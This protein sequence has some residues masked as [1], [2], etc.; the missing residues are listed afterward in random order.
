MADWAAAVLEE[1]DEGCGGG[2]FGADGDEGGEDAGVVVGEVP[3][4]E[5]KVTLLG[6]V[7]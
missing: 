7:R 1:A 3:D 6:R 4:F 2:K 5:C